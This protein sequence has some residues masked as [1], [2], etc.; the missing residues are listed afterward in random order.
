MARHGMAR[1]GKAGA[2]LGQDGRKMARITLYVPDDKKQQLEQLRRQL[3]SSLSEW[4]RSR[5]KA[6]LE[7]LQRMG[8]GMGGDGI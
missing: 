6:E 5:V 8:E 4:V 3:N 2:P 1:Q 7:R